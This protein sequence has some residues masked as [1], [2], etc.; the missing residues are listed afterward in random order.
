MVKQ[1]SF[2]TLESF[3][4]LPQLERPCK[5]GFL[6]KIINVHRASRYPNNY[7]LLII[8]HICQWQTHLQQFATMTLW[9]IGKFRKILPKVWR[10]ASTWV[11]MG[12][13][14]LFRKF[15]NRFFR[16]YIH[17]NSG[18]LSQMNE[19]MNSVRIWIQELGLESLQFLKVSFKSQCW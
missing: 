16:M 3:I 1:Y 5:G 12:N 18:N 10:H 8:D 9:V 11:V 2:S 15:W 17:V 4:T 19:N 13:G 6:K 14:L 7:R